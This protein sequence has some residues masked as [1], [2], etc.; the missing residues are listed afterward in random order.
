MPALYLHA[1]PGYRRHIDA[2]TDATWVCISHQLPC[3]PGDLLVPRTMFGEGPQC[4]FPYVTE[5]LIRPRRTTIHPSAK[6]KILG[7]PDTRQCTYCLRRI[8]RPGEYWAIDHRMPVKLGGAAGYWN[9][10]VTCST[11]NVMKA[12]RLWEPG[13]NLTLGLRLSIEALDPRPSAVQATLLNLLVVDRPPA[14]S[15]PRPMGAGELAPRA[16][17]RTREFSSPDSGRDRRR[18]VP[19]VDLVDEIVEGDVHPDRDDSGLPSPTTA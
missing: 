18:R 19:L 8:L 14:C 9:L 15:D 16:A 13:H 12:A 17:R 5:D 4:L 3:D 7:H 2:H 10:A 11:C 6:L 1:P